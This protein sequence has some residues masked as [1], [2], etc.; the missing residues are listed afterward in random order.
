MAEAELLDRTDKTSARQTENSQLV[1][2]ADPSE[3]R[4]YERI[5]AQSALRNELSKT[6]STVFITCAD[7]AAADC[8][9][10]KAGRWFSPATKKERQIAN[11]VSQAFDGS[12]PKTKLDW[13]PGYVP[14]YNFLHGG[15]SPTSRASLRADR[16]GYWDTV[17]RPTEIKLVDALSQST[18]EIKHKDLV[19]EALRASD[20]DR[21]LAMLTLANFTKS[22]AGIERRQIAPESIA[23]ELKETYTQP[24]IDSIFNRLEGLADNPNE[25]YNKESAVYH[26]YGAMWA[27]SKIGPGSSLGVWAYNNLNLR[28]LGYGGSSDRISESF[29][30]LGAQFWWGKTIREQSELTWPLP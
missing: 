18:G 3:Q 20:N 1:N 30:R 28:P 17:T 11:E 10:G 8:E 24:K 13:G 27:A 21:E 29:S 22:M 19:K 7:G 4:L 15:S 14:L 25:K 5:Q 16:T 12:N 2:L 9:S 23:P 6:N 26:F